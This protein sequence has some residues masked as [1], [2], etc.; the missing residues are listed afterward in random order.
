MS[1]IIRSSLFRDETITLTIQLS[2][3]N[4][5]LAHVKINRFIFVFKTITGAT[6]GGSATLKNNSS[7]LPVWERSR[8]R[9]K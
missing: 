8:W 7:Y 5:Q 6:T 3:Y 1:K 9:S 4:V 2:T